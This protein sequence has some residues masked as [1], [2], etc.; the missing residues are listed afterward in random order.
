LKTLLLLLTTW[1]TLGLLQ[2]TKDEATSNSLLE[3]NLSGSR[4]VN[5]N[6][7]TLQ[8][9][10]RQLNDSRCPT[11]AACIWQGEATASIELQETSS[12]KQQVSLCLGACRND[13][14]FV[15]LGAHTYL[16]KLLAV[17]PYPSLRVP[18]TGP[19]KIRL[20]VSRQ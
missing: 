2:C 3:V 5:V 13:S 6:G 7:A 19:A 16:L 1:V 20:R 11:E 18:P 9:A 17:E 4:K 10:F 15:Q 12:T 8:V 14:A